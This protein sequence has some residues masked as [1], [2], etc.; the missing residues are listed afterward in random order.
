MQKLP[1]PHLGLP[2][3]A[4]YEQL[5]WTL[6]QRLRDERGIDSKDESVIALLVVNVVARGKDL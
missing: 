2:E 4:G 3:T 5:M 6:Y 1:L